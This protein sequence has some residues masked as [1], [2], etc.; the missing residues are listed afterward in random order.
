LNRQDAKSAKGGK[1]SVS[2]ESCESEQS[3]ELVVLLLIFFFAAF[4][5]LRETS[6]EGLTPRRKERKGRQIKLD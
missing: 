3:M 5:P 2:R 4:A 1:E 6:S